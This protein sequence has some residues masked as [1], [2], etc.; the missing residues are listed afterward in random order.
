MCVCVLHWLCRGRAETLK[1]KECKTRFDERHW[2]E[3]SLPEMT[4]RDWRIFR[5]DYNIATKGG[6]IPFPLRS[7]SEAALCGE[8]LEIIHSLNYTV[9]AVVLLIVGYALSLSSSGAHSHPAASYSYWSSEQRHHWHCR[10]RSSKAPN[11]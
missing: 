4:Y 9:C 3:K 5:E 11:I 8:V 6:R 2:K 7:W 1:A 10:N